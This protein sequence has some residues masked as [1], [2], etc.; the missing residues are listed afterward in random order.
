LTPSL[1]LEKLFHQQGLLQLDMPLSI[2]K[3]M[4]LNRVGLVTEKEPAHETTS[5]G[6]GG[7]LVVRVIGNN[8]HVLWD[9]E[10]H[11]RECIMPL[12]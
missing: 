3:A 10:N 4:A 8:D 5:G 9:K 12:P 7:T 2:F 1:C 6:L 11:N